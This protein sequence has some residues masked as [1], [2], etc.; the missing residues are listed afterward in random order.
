M[1]PL[2]STVIHAWIWHDG[3]P[4]FGVP[5]SNYFGWYLTCL[6]FYLGFAL[7]LAARPKLTYSLTRS[8]SQLA[9]VFYGISA[10]GN[11]LVAAPRGVTTVAD[12]TGATWRIHDIYSACA[13][14][15]FFTMGS[16]ALLAWVRARET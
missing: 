3:G 12:A 15:S 13:L 16:F 7:Y 5:V 1:D 4:W 10:G 11:L 9:V 14:T 8:D 6:V 2:W